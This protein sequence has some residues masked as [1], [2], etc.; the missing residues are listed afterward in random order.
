MPDTARLHI[1]L[2]DRQRLFDIFGEDAKGVTSYELQVGS[3]S[4]ETSQL[5]GEF[6]IDNNTAINLDGSVIVQYSPVDSILSLTPSHTV[7]DSDGQ[8]VCNQTVPS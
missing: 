4:R 7:I 8:Y 5:D 1:D 2:S 6:R 3:M